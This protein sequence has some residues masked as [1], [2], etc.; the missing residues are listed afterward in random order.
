MKRILWSVPTLLAPGER[1]PPS[2]RKNARKRFA[3]PGMSGTMIVSS[4]MLPRRAPTRPAL[5]TGGG[6]SE[7][8]DLRSRRAFSSAFFPS[9][10][11]SAYSSRNCL[12]FSSAGLS[13]TCV[14]MVVLLEWSGQ[15]CFKLALARDGEASL[16]VVQAQLH[17]R[18]HSAPHEDVGLVVREVLHAP[19]RDTS[20]A[21]RFHVDRADVVRS[22]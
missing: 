16:Q 22:G 21:F 11:A 20:F 9:F 2:N 7:A 10:G 14:A 13:C 5:S 4:E 19:A 12:V 18:R 8:C 6:K 17:E 15:G 1:L 3:P